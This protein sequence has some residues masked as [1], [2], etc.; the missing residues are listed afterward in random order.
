MARLTTLDSSGVTATGACVPLASVAVF[1]SAGFLVAGGLAASTFLAVDGLASPLA[2]NN[3]YVSLNA[4]V[5]R[6]NAITFHLLGAF[7]H[8][9]TL[10]SAFLATLFA[11]FL[12]HLVSLLASFLATL[13]AAF[14][15]L[16]AFHTFAFLALLALLAF[17]ATFAF[18]PLALFLAMTINKV[19]RGDSVGISR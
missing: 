12:A 8:L 13:L 15:A 14:L 5:W 4:I 1:L 11:S 6:A 18:H 3:Y 9:T 10:L 19:P 17:L 16:L 7:L 2:P